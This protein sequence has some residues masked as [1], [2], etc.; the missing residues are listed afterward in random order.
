MLEQI[1]MMRQR[2]AAAEAQAAA[3]FGR[4]FGRRPSAGHSHG[5]YG[6]YAT[7]MRASTRAGE[8]LAVVVTACFDDNAELHC[9]S[10]Y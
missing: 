7:R 9:S 2:H 4:G 5:V 1:Q 10:V 3:A 8:V 6:A